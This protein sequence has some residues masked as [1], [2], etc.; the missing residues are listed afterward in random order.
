MSMSQYNITAEEYEKIKAAERATK[1]KN[2]SRRLSVLILRYEG[3]TQKEIAGMLR[4]NRVT[5][6]NICRRYH[7]QGLKEFVRCKYT[8]HNQALTYEQEKEILKRFEEAA[9]AGQVITAQ[10]IKRAFDE[11]RGKDTGNVYIY[12]VLKRHN[13]RKVMPRAKHP[14]AASEEACEASKKLKTPCK[15]WQK[16]APK[17]GKE[18]SV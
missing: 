17:K 6:S 14:K 8:S 7:E 1:D 18:K 5:V 16:S 3:H 4:I 10:D 9:N 13:W 2:V 11:V 12:N 15:N